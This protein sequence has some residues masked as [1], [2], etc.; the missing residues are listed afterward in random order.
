MPRDHQEAFGRLLGAGLPARPHPRRPPLGVDRRPAEGRA[1]LRR[2]AVG[3]SSPGHRG[4]AESQG[5]S[6]ARG[7]FDLAAAL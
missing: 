4:N 5:S 6:K 7:K 3:A 2:L 1:A